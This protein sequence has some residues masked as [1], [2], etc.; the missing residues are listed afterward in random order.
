MHI[1]S[2]IIRSKNDILLR[3]VSEAL[4]L[5]FLK[6]DLSLFETVYRCKS[7]VIIE[8]YKEVGGNASNACHAMT[9]NEED[10]TQPA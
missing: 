1:I 5:L 3:N 6:R 9:T 8:R 10:L 2:T 7:V 4:L